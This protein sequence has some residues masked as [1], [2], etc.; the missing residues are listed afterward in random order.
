MSFGSLLAEF[1]PPFWPHREK[2][3]EAAAQRNNLLAEL[4]TLQDD[5]IARLDALDHRVCGVLK[6]WTGKRGAD[7]DSAAPPPLS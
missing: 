6:E 3:L 5:L 1:W 4:E 2:H 7:D